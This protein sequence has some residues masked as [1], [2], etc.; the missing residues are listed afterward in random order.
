MRFGGES[1]FLDAT[2]PEARDYVWK[3]CKKN[4]YDHGIEVFWLDEAEPEYGE[5]DFDNYRYYLGTVNQVGNVYPQLY[6]RMFYDGMKAENQKDI[7]NL[8]RCAWAGSQRYGALVWSGDIHCDFATFRRQL[9]AGL[10]MGIAG[11]P[12]WTTDIG[13]F[14]GGDPSTPEFRELLIRWFQWGCFCPVMRLHGDRKPTV[15]PVYRK[16][17]STSLFTGSDNE[18]WSYGDEAYEILV[19]YIKLRELLRP[20]TRKL[21]Q[22]AHENGVPVMRPMFLEFPESPECWQLKDQYMYGPDM[23]VAPVMQANAVSRKVYLPSG[24]EWTEL[25]SG[26]TYQGGVFVDAEAPIEKIPVFLKNGSHK[27]LIGAV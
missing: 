24:A 11:I 27:E 6:S 20:Y 8:V 12:W 2:N 5:Y 22:E 7:V 10:N 21:M 25:H 17:G 4:Y 14:H 1:M 13:G 18:V 15:Q 16:D 26:K 3:K 23:L 9:C 19:K